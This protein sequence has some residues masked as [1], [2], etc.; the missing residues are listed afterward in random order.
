MTNEYTIAAEKRDVAVKRAAL[1]A[2]NKIPAVVYGM[3]IDSIMLLS[4]L[5]I[6]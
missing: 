1:T 3:G 6:K 2:E 5:Y 4:T